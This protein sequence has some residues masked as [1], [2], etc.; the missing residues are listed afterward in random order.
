LARDPEYKFIKHDTLVFCRALPLKLKFKGER[1]FIEDV[2]FRVNEKTHKI[3]SV[4]YKLSA[5]TEKTILGMDWEDAARLTLLTF[6]E[7]Y[8]TAYCLKDLGY[9][10]KVFADD[11]YIVVGRVLKPSTKKFNDSVSG[12][13]GERTVYEQKSKKQYIADLQKSFASKEF[14]NLRFESCNAARGTG[15]KD[16]IYAVQVRQLYYS[17]NYADDGILTLAIDMRNETNPLVRVRVWQQE[18][19]VTYNAEQMIEQTVSTGQGIN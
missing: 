8:R 5:T 2:V 4:A 15:S 9:I 7:D 3:E 14:V 1:S 10:N 16:G 13:L 6:L 18:R 12:V 17:N 11:A 19:D